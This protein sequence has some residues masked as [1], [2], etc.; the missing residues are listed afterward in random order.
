[1]D[2]RGL[3]LARSDALRVSVEPEPA[4]A[5]KEIGAELARARRRVFGA[6]DQALV[7][8]V[9]VEV[10]EPRDRVAHREV[11]VEVD[12]P[13]E[14]LAGATGEERRAARRTERARRTGE[15][16]AHAVA[17]GVEARV[18]VLAEELVGLDGEVRAHRRAGRDRHDTYLAVEPVHRAELADRELALAVAVEIVELREAAAEADGRTERGEQGAGRARANVDVG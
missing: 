10:T 16:V 9:A 3:D 15:V 18:D 6:P 7:E 8:A 11:G 14:T 17:V 5:E 1:M 4:A 2:R 13:V 12:E